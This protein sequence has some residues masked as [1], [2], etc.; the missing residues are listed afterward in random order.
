MTEKLPGNANHIQWWKI[1]VCVLGIVMIAGAITYS[2]LTRYSNTSG[3]SSTNNPVAAGSNNTQGPPG[4]DSLNWAKN[5]QAKFTNLDFLFVLLPGND[6][7]A[8]KTEQTISGAMEKI[9]QDGA[10]VGIFALDPQ[11]PEVSITAERLSVSKLPAVLLFSA[12]GS[13]AIVTGDITET[14]LLQA[15]LTVLKTCVPGNSGCCPK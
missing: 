12:T 9:S 13:G 14:K 11:D 1:A 4:I 5:V 8:K 6:D 2:M 10:R 15:Y 7:L 3:A